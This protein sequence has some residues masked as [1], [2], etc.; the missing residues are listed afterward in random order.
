MTVQNITQNPAS[1][2]G[3]DAEELLRQVYE[4]RFDHPE[5]SIREATLVVEGETT[6]SHAIVREK[7]KK[8]RATGTSAILRPLT[9][10]QRVLCRRYSRGLMQ[11]ARIAARR[12]VATGRQ[13]SD[14]VHDLIAWLSELDD[15]MAQLK[16]STRP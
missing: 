5:L 3:L 10:E 6:V 16:A 9:A 7:L 12:P 8:T 2:N 13:M 4:L 11:M 14:R 1:G 15:V